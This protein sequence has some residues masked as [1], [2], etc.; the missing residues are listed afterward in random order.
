MKSLFTFSSCML[1][2]ALC[3]IKAEFLTFA[4]YLGSLAWNPYIQRHIHTRTHTLQY[5]FKW[6]KT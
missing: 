5:V 2:Q 4:P 3:F 1:H 6:G